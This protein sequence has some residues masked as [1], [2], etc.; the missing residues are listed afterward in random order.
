MPP[1]LLL[2]R[3]RLRE[4]AERDAG[5]TS[6]ATADDDDRDDDDIDDDVDSGGDW[7]GDGDGV[8]MVVRGGAVVRRSYSPCDSASCT[9]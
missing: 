2:W 5:S 6:D 8:S 9:V 3:V 1:L 7:D 4:S